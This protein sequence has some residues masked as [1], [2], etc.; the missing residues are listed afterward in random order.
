MARYM[1]TLDW[2]KRL[3]AR[4]TLANY[5]FLSDHPEEAAAPLF[6]QA[7]LSRGAER[8]WPHQQHRARTTR[9]VEA[10]D[11]EDWTHES[12]CSSVA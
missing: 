8:E 1:P 5:R 9:P 11:L 6:T 2:T 3:S 4:A 10:T 7:A 12:R